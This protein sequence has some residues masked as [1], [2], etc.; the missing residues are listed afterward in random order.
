[1][2]VSNGVCSDSSCVTVNVEMLCPLNKD[3]AVPNAFS[4]NSDGYNDQFCLQ[5]W[6]NCLTE[7]KIYIYDRWGE[8]VFESTDASFCWDGIYKG[9]V[10]DPAVFV[11]YIKASFANDMKIEKK[12]NITII[13]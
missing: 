4:P 11:Y 12:G 10:L 8:K 2:Q 6:N 13:R 7:F 1:V 5:G 9:Q 3:L